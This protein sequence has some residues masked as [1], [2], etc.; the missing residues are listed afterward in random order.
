MEPITFKGKEN[1]QSGVDYFHN[2]RSS[3][4]KLI[5]GL[6]MLGLAIY[7]YNTIGYN[8]D[9]DVDKWAQGYLVPFMGK[10]SGLFFSALF[11]AICS[12]SIAV[13]LFKGLFRIYT[14]NK[15][16]DTFEGKN[17]AGWSCVQTRSSNTSN[18]D[19]AYAYRNFKAQYMTPDKAAEFYMET[20]RLG[21][22][23]ADSDTLGYVNS[24]MGMMSPEQKVSFLQG[25]K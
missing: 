1:N 3:A 8:G 2:T 12:I 9:I 5:S 6:I 19:E 24:K 22:S 4:K 23:M 14:F 25:K 13:F 20:S 7:G 11:G 18:I 16:I 10:D 15:H 21:N 17:V